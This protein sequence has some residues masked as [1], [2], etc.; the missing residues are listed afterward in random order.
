MNVLYWLC[1]STTAC[2]ASN[3]SK[4]LYSATDGRTDTSLATISNSSGQAWLKL[5]L[6]ST[7]NVTRF[8]LRGAYPAAPTVNPSAATTWLYV[9]LS[10]G[11]VQQALATNSSSTYQYV[12]VTGSWQN[13]VALLV[14]ASASFSIS[15]VA[16]Q[17][18]PCA[19]WATVDL[20]TVQ[21]LGSV[22]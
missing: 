8:S 17:V 22:R 9:Q 15:E 6:P 7:A 18:A 16:A 11:A 5:T 21:E 2:T 19:Q 14:N 20:G 4:T 3:G 13:V 1:N 10:S 12:T